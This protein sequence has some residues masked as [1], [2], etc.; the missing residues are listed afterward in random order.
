MNFEVCVDLFE[1][2]ILRIRHHTYKGIIFIKIILLFSRYNNSD[3]ANTSSS[4]LLFVDIN[5]ETGLYIFS[6]GIEKYI[7]KCN[8]I[9]IFALGMFFLFL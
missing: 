1:I 5:D 6:P 9:C 3:E 2:R 8:G 4:S 7:L